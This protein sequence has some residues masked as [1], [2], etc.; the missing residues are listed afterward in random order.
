MVSRP[1][2]WAS[3]HWNLCPGWS[4]GSRL[5]FS[6]SGNIS[7][8]CQRAAWNTFLR[9]QV[10][11]KTDMVCSKTIT[12]ETW[13]VE[14]LEINK[15]QFWHTAEIAPWGWT[16]STHILWIISELWLV[17]IKNE[18]MSEIM[19]QIPSPWPRDIKFLFSERLC[20]MGKNKPSMMSTK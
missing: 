11:H 1:Q 16:F 12:T 9:R 13:S 5:H 14:G 19:P 18:P 15:Y 17:D 7:L 8:F 6:Q 2:G 20:I 4:H 3:R 10:H